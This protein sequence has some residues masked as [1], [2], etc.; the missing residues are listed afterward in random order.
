[1]FNIEDKLFYREILKFLHEEGPRKRKDIFLHC[2]TALRIPADVVNRRIKSSRSAL[3]KRVEWLCQSLKNAGLVVFKGKNGPDRG[4]LELTQE[5]E[6]LVNAKAEEIEK[7]VQARTGRHK[8]ERTESTDGTLVKMLKTMLCTSGNIVLT[9]APGTGK[10]FLAKKLAEQLAEGRRDHVEFVQFHPSYDYTDFVEGL[11]PVAGEDGKSIGFERKDGIFKELCKKAISGGLSGVEDNFEAAWRRLLDELGQSDKGVMEISNL[12]GGTFSVELNERDNGLVSR[13]YDAENHSRNGRLRFYCSHD[14]LYSV[15]RGGKGYS[16]GAHDN[17]RRAIL[18][19]MQGKK[20]G[21]KEYNAGQKTKG[22]ESERYVLIIDEIN[23]GDISKIFGELFYSID[24]GYRG[25]D[26]RVKTQYSN[27]LPDSDVFKEGFYVPKNVYIIGTMN[28]VDR[29][30]ESMDFAIRRR[31]RWIEIKP[32]DRC[33]MLEGLGKSLRTMCERVMKALN[34]K[35][36]QE[37]ALGTAYQIGPAYFLKLKDAKDKDGGW[38]DLWSRDLEP[39]LREYLRGVP[40]SENILK[41]LEQTYDAAV[42]GM[43]QED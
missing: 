30:V 26:G 39:L 43:A 41:E 2:V 38:S 24:P 37:G 29:G 21:L 10:T 18:K 14:Q 15:Y 4:L 16:S 3:H 35:I 12:S 1:M 13:V 31:F 6:G 32:E 17:Y 40:N 5:G 22:D 27:L 8:T 23:R 20:F 36:S 7:L 42:S 19:H 25:E 11:R 9:G 34:G 28:D 33:E